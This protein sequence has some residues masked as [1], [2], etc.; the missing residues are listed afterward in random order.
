MKTVETARKF[1]EDAIADGWSHE[2]IYKLEDEQ[3]ACMLKRDG[4]LVMVLS[5]DDKSSSIAAWGPPKG[6]S[7]RLSSWV[8]PGF[9]WF[10][11]ATRRC[12]ICEAEDVDTFRYSFAGRACSKCVTAARAEFEKPGWTR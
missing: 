2:P 6:L 12:N 10:L 5:R 11:T 3:R 7:I 1:V 4:F 9:A 8:Y